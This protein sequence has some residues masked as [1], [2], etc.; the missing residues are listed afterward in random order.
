MRRPFV[1]YPPYAWGE[2]T[3]TQQM[4]YE[5]ALALVEC[6]VSKGDAVF[7]ELQ[8]A[9]LKFRKTQHLQGFGDREEFVDLHGQVRS[10]LRQVR[11]AVERRRGDRLHQASEHI[12]RHMRP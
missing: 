8:V 7:G 12:G 10:N 3:I 4:A 1:Q 6:P 5:Y 11:L 9:A 2:R